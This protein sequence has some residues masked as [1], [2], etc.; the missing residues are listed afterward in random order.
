M[1][2]YG[3]KKITIDGIT[4]DSMLE[5]AFYQ[6][7]KALKQA[8]KIHSFQMQVPFVLHGG[9]KYKLDFLILMESAQDFLTR[10]YYNEKNERVEGKKAIPL[11]T[12]T[13]K[14]RYVEVKGYWTAVAKLKRKLFEADYGKLEIHTKD[15][16]WSLEPNIVASKTADSRGRSQ[17]TNAPGAVEAAQGSHG[18]GKIPAADKNA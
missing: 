8:G 9:I 10:V 2:K 3:N 5:G 12:L 15:K 16:P 13:Q 17:R 4:F 18:G 6:K 14:N 1:S 11:D 7:L